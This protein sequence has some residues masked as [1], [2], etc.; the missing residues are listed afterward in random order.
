MRS[1]GRDSVVEATVCCPCKRSY[2]LCEH[3]MHEISTGPCKRS[4]TLREHMMHEISTAKQKQS[5][6][7]LCQKQTCLVDLI[8][9][10]NAN[11]VFH[12]R[13]ATLYRI[14]GRKCPLKD[15]G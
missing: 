9:N 7:G 13:A 14:R 1:P 3:M 11:Q 2:T 8:L 15:G 4:Y 6:K 12:I 5:L 10:K